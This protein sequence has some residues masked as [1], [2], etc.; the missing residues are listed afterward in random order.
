MFNADAFT[1]TEM[2]I[3]SALSVLVFAMVLTLLLVSLSLWREGMARHQ[4]SADSRI[5]RERI[6]H[7]IDGQFGLRHAQRSLIT[8]T[9]DQ[10]DFYDVASSN[11]FSL[12]WPSNRPPAYVDRSGT[13][14]LIR[15][16]SVVDSIAIAITNDILNIDL[17]LAITNAGKKYTQPQQLRVYLLNE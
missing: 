12:L 14:P 16:G 17:T 3:A 8:V 7:G 9:S 11:E 13:Q 4:L 15:S 10:I 5:V 2:L 6:L 1:L